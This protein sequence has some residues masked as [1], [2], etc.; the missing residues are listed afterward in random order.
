M[1]AFDPDFA[2]MRLNEPLG[3]GQTQ[4]HAGGVTIHSDEI[5]KN[6]LVMF[7]GDAWT[8]IRY[9][10]LHAIGAGQPETPAFLSRRHAGY[11]T[12]PEMR[13]RMQRDASARGRM[14]QRIVQQVGRGL[15]HLLVIKSKSR[16]GRVETGIKVHALALECFRPTLCQ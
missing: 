7:R 1:F 15:L 2:A 4:T 6:F 3:D 14:F 10:D 16:D 11:T 9:A 5:F 13:S 12:L 8:G